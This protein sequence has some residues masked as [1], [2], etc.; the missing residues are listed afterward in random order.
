MMGFFFAASSISSVIGAP[1]SVN[2]LRLD[3]LMGLAGWQWLFIIEGVPAVILAV[4]GYFMLR[5]HPEDA[6]WLSSAEK[7]WLRGRLDAEVASKPTHG[8]GLLASI[9]NPQIVVLTIAFAF[10]LY[11]VYSISFFLPLIIKGLGL[12][13]LA[14]G[15]VTALPSLCAALGQ[16]AISRSSDFSGERFWHVICAVTI[17]GLGM[18]A[19]AFSLGNVYVAMLAFCVAFTG[20]TCTLPVFWNLPTAYFGAASAAAGI[21]AINTIGNMSGYLAP[22][23]MG[24]LHD[25]TGGYVVPLLVAAGLALSAPVLIGLS[26]IKRYVQRPG[27][28]A[29]AELP[30]SSEAI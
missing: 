30:A 2:L 27:P 23:F 29:T 25:R 8:R 24:L 22:Q 26:G 6:P 28:L 13:N 9:F 14:V 5:D 4:V 20:L 12:S 16:I 10:T 18:L 19:T 17:G 11:G 1:I 3:S 21:G 15:Y 7:T